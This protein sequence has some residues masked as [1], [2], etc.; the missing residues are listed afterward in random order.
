VGHQLLV[1]VDVNLLGDK[2]YKEQEVLERT[3]I[4]LS[5]YTPETA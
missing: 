2:W 3:N 5:F 1:Y 4:L